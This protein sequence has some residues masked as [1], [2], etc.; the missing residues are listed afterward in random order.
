MTM[1]RCWILMCGLMLVSEGVMYAQN[2]GEVLERVR[3]KYDSVKDAEL[4][5]TQTVKFETARIEQ[6]FRGTLLLK[7]ENKYRLETGELV[8][9]TDGVAVWSHSQRTDQVLID[10]FKLDDRSVTPERIL[11]GAPKDYYPSLLGTEKIAGSDVIGLKLV[12][13]NDDSMIKSLKLWVDSKDW[14]IKRAEILDVHGKET[15]YTVNE[16]RINRGIPDSQFSYQIPDGV[17]VVDL[18]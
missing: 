17:E 12:P 6:E 16:T 2:A 13:K 10:R 14:L 1:K 18:R 5:F 3:K 8:L 11:A 9:V 7:K 4:S 15:V